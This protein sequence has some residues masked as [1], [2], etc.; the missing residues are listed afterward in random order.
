M[1]LETRWLAVAALPIIVGLLVG[2]YIT[3]VDAFGLSFERAL[4]ETT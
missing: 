3:K 2:G 4:N 1:Q